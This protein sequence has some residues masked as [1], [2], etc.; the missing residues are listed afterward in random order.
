M[1]KN[2]SP[3]EPKTNPLH[4]DQQSNTNDV[5]QRLKKVRYNVSSTRGPT[6]TFK[7]KGTELYGTSDG[8]FIAE[9]PVYVQKIPLVPDPDPIGADQRWKITMGL[10]MKMQGTSRWWRKVYDATLYV[11]A[12]PFLSDWLHQSAPGN[13]A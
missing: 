1:P 5:I 7:E 6:H 8:G 3:W 11:L 12:R 4:E 10:H 2:L 13:R 9:S